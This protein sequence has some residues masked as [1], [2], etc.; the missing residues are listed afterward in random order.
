MGTS[1]SAVAQTMGTNCG[2][3]LTL[4]IIALLIFGCSSPTAPRAFSTGH[5]CNDCRTPADTSTKLG[6]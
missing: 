3:L 6:R 2:R 5:P 1:F 4:I